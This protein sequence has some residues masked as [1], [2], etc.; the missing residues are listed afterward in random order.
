MTDGNLSY[1]GGCILRPDHRFHLPDGKQVIMEVE[2]A[3]SP[4][5]LPR[6]LESLTHRQAFFKSESGKAFLPQIRMVL[7]VKPGASLRRTMAIWETGLREIFKKTGEEPAFRLF[8]I[9]LETFLESPEW[10]EILSGR[11]EEIRLGLQTNQA[12]ENVT[13]KSGN[14]SRQTL[15]DQIIL[16]L[17]L[18]QDF[19]KCIPEANLRPNT[20]IIDVARTIFDASYGENSG[21]VKNNPTIPTRS[22]FLFKEFL[23]MNP[24]LRTK[25]KQAIHVNRGKMVMNQVNILHRMNLIIRTFLRYFGWSGRGD[26]RACATTDERTFGDT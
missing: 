2:Q 19:R 20:M 21:Q 11:W 10:N 4:A 8:A 3:A 9:P 26:I 1:G 25:L 13:S 17:A 14:H 23:S 7:N 18:D 12:A 24:D 15:Q 6:I 16:L 5:L 22:L